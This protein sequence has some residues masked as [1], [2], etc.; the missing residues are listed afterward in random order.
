MKCVNT[1]AN[2]VI[3]GYRAGIRDNNMNY[4]QNS[5]IHLYNNVYTLIIIISYI[6]YVTKAR[7]SNS[8]QNVILGHDSDFLFMLPKSSVYSS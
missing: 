1:F 7:H 8:M 4:Y 3:T 2:S 5:S 6:S